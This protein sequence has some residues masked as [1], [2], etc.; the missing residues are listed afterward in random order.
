MATRDERR[1]IGG[2]VWAKADAV[3]RD[4]KRIYGKELARTWLR[5]T[6]LQVL[7]QKKTPAQKRAS[8]YIKALYMVGL[9]EKVAIITISRLKATDPRLVVEVPAPAPPA[10]P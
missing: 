2:F 9:T 3:S 1:I 5:G 10:P 8:T 7:S 6:V 4:A